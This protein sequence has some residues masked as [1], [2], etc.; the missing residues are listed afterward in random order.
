MRYEFPARGPVRIHA[1]IRSSDLAVTAADVETIEVDVG[2]PHDD[3]AAV[4]VDL[5]GDVLRLEVP[6]GGRRLFG[7]RSRL[8]LAVR[9]PERSA[10]EVT[11]GSGDVTTTGPLAQVAGRSGSGD[12]DVARTDD[13]EITS[14]SGDITVASLGT[15]HVTTGSGDLDLGP[16]AGLVRVRTGSGDVVA[17]EADELEA[18]TASGDILIKELRG[19]ATVKTAS[20]DVHVRR[21]SGG[22]LDAVTASGDVVVRVVEGTAALLDCS[23]VSGSVSSALEPA[24]E[25]GPGEGSITV[26]A[27]TV[28]GN[29]TVLR[30][31]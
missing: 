24:A 23:S 13:L 31:A 6:S 15:A 8:H 22:H 20:G 11:T 29:V 30:T 19:R 3:E 18:V 12:L 2:G 4:R 10:L 1:T 17:A 21:G 9:V 27:R 28:S 25:P 7:G 14:G 5:T 26:R 16:A